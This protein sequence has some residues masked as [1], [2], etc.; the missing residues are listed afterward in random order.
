M[1]RWARLCSISFQG[2]GNREANLQTALDL[3]EQ[4]LWDKPDL[5]LLP[6]T[7]TG[8]GMSECDWFNTAEPLDGETVTRLANIARQHRTYIACPVLLKHRSAIHNATILLDRN[9][10]MAGSYYKMFPTLGELSLGITPGAEATVVD[11]DFGKVGFAICF[12][13]NFREVADDLHAK[14][15]E[16]VCFSSMY[17]GG[18]QIQHW[19]L[20][21][22]WWMLSAIG[23]PQGMLVDPLG[24][25]RKRA[26]P[27]YQPMLSALV[28]LDCLVAHLDYNHDKAQQIKHD[29]GCEV[30]VDILQEEARFLLTCHRQDVTAADLARQYDLL[31]WDEYFRRARHE[32]STRIS[33]M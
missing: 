3:L 33:Q 8:L 29:H 31:L 7:F 26:Q 12:D 1:A 14:G 18:T 15:A 11:T 17:P 9:G 24:R 32:R 6:E 2:Q 4:A 28:N 25:V 21:H 10:E 13:L 23:S 5:V 20:E 27:N 19:A 22:H 30:E 16:L